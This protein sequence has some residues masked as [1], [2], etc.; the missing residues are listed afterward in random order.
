MT[1]PHPNPS[2]KIKN[3]QSEPQFYWF[4][5]KSVYCKVTAK[6]LDLPLEFV[7]SGF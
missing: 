3:S 6:Q 2:P 4:L 5:Y 7:I 1:N